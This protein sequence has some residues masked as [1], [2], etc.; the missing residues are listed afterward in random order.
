MTIASAVT[1]CSDG[2][3]SLPLCPPGRRARLN[4]QMKSIINI[5]ILML[6]HM[7]AN[8]TDNRPS[9]HT[10]PVS[11]ILGAISL[12]M[13]YLTTQPDQPSISPQP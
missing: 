6:C 2:N 13:I 12:N 11:T 3:S 7:A 1:E 5:L 8:A 9:T 4:G 10:S